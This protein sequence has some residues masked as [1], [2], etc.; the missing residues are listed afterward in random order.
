MR[1]L[2]MKQKRLIASAKHFT[3]ELMRSLEKEND[4]ETLYHDAVRLFDDLQ[5]QRQAQ[6][7]YRAMN[8]NQQRLYSEE[9]YLKDWR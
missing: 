8:Y 9:K 5:V 1:K 2:S 7:I 4:Y 6:T 3:P